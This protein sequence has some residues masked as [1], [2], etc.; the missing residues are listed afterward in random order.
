MKGFVISASLIPYTTQVKALQPM[1][2]PS[3]RLPFIE[4]TLS[5]LRK[6]V[7]G[8]GVLQAQTSTQLHTRSSAHTIHTQALQ[9]L[10]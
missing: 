8:T 1:L 2:D 5:T 3:A 4:T 6:E 9:L 10:L 7:D